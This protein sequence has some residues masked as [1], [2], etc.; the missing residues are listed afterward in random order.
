MTTWEH[1]ADAVEHEQRLRR[2][3]AEARH[4]FANAVLSGDKQAENAWW[5]LYSGLVDEWNV[6]NQQ[7]REHPRGGNSV[8]NKAGSLNRP[9]P[10]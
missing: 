3:I 10:Q 4:K 5:K 2:F 7:L 8:I 1:L 9:F 6:L